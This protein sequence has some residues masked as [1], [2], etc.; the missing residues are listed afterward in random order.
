MGIRYL[1][2]ESQQ[3]AWKYLGVPTIHDRGKIRTPVGRTIYLRTGIMGLKAAV[4]T[5]I[6]AK[7]KARV[8]II[9]LYLDFPSLLKMCQRDC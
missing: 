7:I 2:D 5:A 4:A 6:A 1:W 3:K 8:F 9:F